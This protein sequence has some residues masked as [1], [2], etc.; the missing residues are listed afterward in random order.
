MTALLRDKRLL[1]LPGGIEPPTLRLTAV[2]T[3]YYAMEA[4]LRN[5]CTRRAT[6]ASAKMI[7]WVQFYSS[8]LRMVFSIE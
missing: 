6:E 8:C 5:P 4:D 1:S 7:F 3:T 2:R